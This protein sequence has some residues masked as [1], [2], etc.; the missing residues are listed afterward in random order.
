MARFRYA[1]SAVFQ[2]HWRV[3]FTDGKSYKIVWYKNYLRKSARWGAKAQREV[4]QGEY[5]LIFPERGVGLRKLS[6]GSPPEE[7]IGLH[8]R[9]PQFFSE[10]TRIFQAISINTR[11]CL[12][13]AVVN[14]QRIGKVSNPAARK[15]LI[16]SFIFAPAGIITAQEILPSLERCSSSAGKP[17]FFICSA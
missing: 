7:T 3:N 10:D 1:N 4:R 11:C 13:N 5:L 17:A 12:W 8:R 6:L 14:N 15:F 9:V 16:L 2:R